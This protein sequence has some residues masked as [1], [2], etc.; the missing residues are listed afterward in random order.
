[1]AVIIW[2]CW[3]GMGPAVPALRLHTRTTGNPG[4]SN[5]L[6]IASVF[7]NVVSAYGLS[8][9]LSPVITAMLTAR[10]TTR[11]SGTRGIRALCRRG[12]PGGFQSL[13]PHGKRY[14]GAGE[15]GYFT[16]F[17]RAA[18]GRWRTWRPRRALFLRC[19]RSCEQR[20][21]TGK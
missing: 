19:H 15:P 3:P 10:A 21:D 6:F 5:D 11:L 2:I 13:L 4:Y 12:L 16:A 17:T 8:N 7:T 9:S 14:A 1:V 18:W 20:L